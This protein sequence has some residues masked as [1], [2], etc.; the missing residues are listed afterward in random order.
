MGEL[1]IMK[2]SCLVLVFIPASVFGADSSRAQV[3]AAGLSWIARH[4]DKEG[5]WSFNTYPKLCKDETC[6]GPGRQESLSAATALALLPML[7]AG[8]THLQDGPY[9]NVIGRGI[10][11]LKGHQKPDGDLSAGADQQMYSHGF[12]AIAL[13]EAYGMT[14]SA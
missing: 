8:Q 14:K 6:T 10:D 7:G 13:C 3:V 4:Q 9:K 5:N 12:A 2:T 1:Y 11:W